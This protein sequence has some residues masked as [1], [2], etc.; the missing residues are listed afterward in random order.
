MWALPRPCPRARRSR[1]RGDAIVE[2]GQRRRQTD[3][4]FGVDI[5]VVSGETSLQSLRRFVGLVSEITGLRKQH[6]PG[7][8]WPLSQRLGP[9]FSRIMIPNKATMRHPPV[10]NG[11]ASIRPTR[12][13]DWPPRFL[14]CVELLR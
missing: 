7:I 4:G 11:P 14:H 13:D 2:A 3:T 6:Y 10:R 8:P 12:W 9:I 5:G 1:K